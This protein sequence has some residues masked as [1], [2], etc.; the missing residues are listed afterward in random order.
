MLNTAE[1]RFRQRASALRV[2][3]GIGSSLWWEPLLCHAALR[4]ARNRRDLR[5]GTAETGAVTLDGPPGN[6]L[7]I[8]HRVR[9][10]AAPSGEQKG[11][12]TSV[13]ERRGRWFHRG[14]A[15]ADAPLEPDSDQ[16]QRKRLLVTFIRPEG[17]EKGN[18]RIVLKHCEKNSILE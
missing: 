17:A 14:D 5:P 16:N 12:L 11:R 7:Q 1:G 18:C 4:H 13:T 6:L 9:T 8:F 3:R 15:N 2:S 10:F